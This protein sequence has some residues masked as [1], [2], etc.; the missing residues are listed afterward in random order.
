MKKIVVLA[1]AI[2]SITGCCS[3]K[4]SANGANSPASAEA[5]KK[6]AEFEV[7]KEGSFGGRKTA[8]NIVIS[9]R[10]ELV[11]LYS[12]LKW[13]DVPTVD[14]TKNNVVAL[15]M[16][17]RP[18]GGYSIALDKLEINGNAAV[19][20]VVTKQSDGM[21]ASVMTQPYYIAVITKTEK[22]TFK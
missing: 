4:K 12:E 1:V 15:F 17:E 11:S 22:V 10:Q 18:S 5:V 7:L 6:H 21:A 2:I 3:Q 8:S 20:S 9:S 14:F 19:V 16:G 13:D